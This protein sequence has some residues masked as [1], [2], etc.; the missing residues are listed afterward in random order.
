MNLDPHWLKERFKDDSDQELR[1]D[2]MFALNEE[3]ETVI[4]AELERREK[5][6]N[7]HHKPML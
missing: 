1:F 7:E 3:V 2:L 6:A 4:K 5:E